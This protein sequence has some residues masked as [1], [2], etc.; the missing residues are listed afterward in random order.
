[1]LHDLLK[2]ACSLPENQ[3]RYL[4]DNFESIVN[5]LD[6]E[7]SESPKHDVL[8]TKSE[9]KKKK[10]KKKDYYPIVHPLPRPKQYEE[11]YK[12]ENDSMSSNP[13][14]PIA[15]GRIDIVASYI[16]GDMNVALDKVAKLYDPETP[17]QMLKIIDLIDK[18]INLDEDISY[19]NMCIFLFPLS[20]GA[21]RVAL[22]PMRLIGLTKALWSLCR[23]HDRIKNRMKMEQSALEVEGAQT[24][25]INSI[26]E[27]DEVK[28][29]FRKKISSIRER[30]NKRLDL[31]KSDEVELHLDKAQKAKNLVPEDER[32]GNLKSNIAGLKNQGWSKEAFLRIATSLSYSTEEIDEATK[33]VFE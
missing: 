33:E 14:K 27:L 32:I 2:K 8:Q 26:S 16:N 24:E 30:I 10:K 29:S 17:E 20:R 15:S 3:K 6:E 23:K 18:F 28:S 7:F 25:P 4:S 5:V 12:T 13:T 9:K 11:D 31:D 19:D 1:M 22:R 21:Q